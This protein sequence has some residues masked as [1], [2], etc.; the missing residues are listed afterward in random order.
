M[1]KRALKSDRT[2]E[3][4][5]EAAEPSPERSEKGSAEVDGMYKRAAKDLADKGADDPKEAA[6]IVK[7]A[8]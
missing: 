8:R 7:K 6:K 3:P 4:G 5:A 1:K 2:S